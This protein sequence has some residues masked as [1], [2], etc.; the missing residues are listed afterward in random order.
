MTGHATQEPTAGERKLRVVYVGHV[1]KL[2]GG[3]IALAR[4]IDALDDVDAHVILAEDGPLV[5]RLQA[6]GASVEVLPMRDRTRNL[7]KGRLGASGPPLTAVFDTAAYVFRLA[8]RL[9]Q[10]RPDLVH[11]NTLKAGIYGSLAARLAHVPVVWHVRDRIAE[12]YLRRPTVLVVRALIAALPSGVIVNSEATQKTLWPV[13]RVRRVVHSPVYDPVTAQHVRLA[14]RR[15]QPLLVGMIGRIAPWKGQHVFLEAF[16]KAFPQGSEVAVLVGEAMFGEA[17]A[18]YAASLRTMAE[19]LGIADRVE[20]RGFREDVWAELERLDLFVHASV[21]PEPFGQVIV[22]AMHAGVPVI[23]S[24]SGGP[25][26][27]VTNEVDGLLYTPGDVDALAI[28]LRRLSGDP[29]LR[30]R[31][32]VN[33][34]MRAE[35]F[36]PEAAA[37][38]VMALYSQVLASGNPGA[39]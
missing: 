4:L 20:F 2:S 3:E 33:A 32:C 29:V 13:S 39:G 15:N 14:P 21:T 11:T 9:R 5:A 6:A 36:S 18:Q 28:D 25:T 8:R 7:R 24:A 16:A 12:D 35:E 31:L 30:T 27:I 26:E 38:G 34:L 22:E 10:L 19:T 37:A 17:E 1:A 23:A